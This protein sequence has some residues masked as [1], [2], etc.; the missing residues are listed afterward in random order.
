VAKAIV[1]SK[2]KRVRVPS[3]GCVRALL[4]GETGGSAEIAFAPLEMSRLLAVWE[5]AERAKKTPNDRVLT[6]LQFLIPKAKTLA[7]GI[8][9][10]VPIARTKRV[11]LV[12]D[13][14]QNG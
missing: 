3:F 11:N 8:V 4:F 13:F 1:N 2:D 9:A 5:E 14:E 7:P 10:E 12:P 6:A